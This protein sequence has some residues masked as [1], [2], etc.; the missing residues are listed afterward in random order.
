MIRQRRS[1]S[2]AWRELERIKSVPRAI[3][4]RSILTAGSRGRSGVPTCDH[5]NECSVMV[6]CSIT[7]SMTTI[8]HLHRWNASY[9]GTG[10]TTQGTH[11]VASFPRHLLHS[12]SS[13]SRCGA[14]GVHMGKSGMVYRGKAASTADTSDI[15]EPSAEDKCVPDEAGVGYN[16]D[17]ETGKVCA[18][19][20]DPNRD[21]RVVGTSW[22]YR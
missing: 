16:I 19:C 1:V 2:L 12:Y 11:R 15:R 10:S 8:R 6:P 21:L 13:G 9:V 17:F 5:L 18:G 22:I 4:R 20:F 14:N 3:A 7:T